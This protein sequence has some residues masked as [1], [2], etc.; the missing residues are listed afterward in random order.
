MVRQ[1]DPRTRVQRN[2]MH[3]WLNFWSCFRSINSRNWKTLITRPAQLPWN[4]GRNK[5]QAS[6]WNKA[7][8][9]FQGTS[10]RAG[11]LQQHRSCCYM[12]F[13][14]PEVSYFSIK[15]SRVWAALHHILEWEGGGGSLAAIPETAY[16]NTLKKL[17]KLETQICMSLSEPSCTLPRRFLFRGKPRN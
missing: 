13:L 3:I 1:I 11:W 6:C 15:L 17:L 8:V 10:S 12:C 7:A 14:Y 2:V 16:E 4:D 9:K 5:I